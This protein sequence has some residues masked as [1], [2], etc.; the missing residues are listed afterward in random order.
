MKIAIGASFLEYIPEENE[1]YNTYGL[2]FSD[3]ASFFHRKDIPTALENFCYRKG[4]EEMVFDT[5]LSLQRMHR[6]KWLKYWVFLYFTVVILA[7]S[8]VEV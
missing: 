4:D 6:Q 8:Q 1:S 7:P 3:R 5:P 2:F